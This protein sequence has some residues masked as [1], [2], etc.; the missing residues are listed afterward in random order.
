[1][2]A[3][4]VAPRQAPATYSAQRTKAVGSV[5][6]LGYC[7]E[8]MLGLAHWNNEGWKGERVSRLADEPPIE[9]PA[10]PG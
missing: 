4:L 9:V 1:L 2:L 8:H 10:P 7:Q 5:G 3:L 6:S